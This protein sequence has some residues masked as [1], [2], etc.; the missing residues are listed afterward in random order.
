MDFDITDPSDWPKEFRPLREIDS[1]LRCP[2]CKEYLRAAMMLQ[3]HHNFCSECIRRHLDKESTCPACRVSTSTSQ[4][5]RNV[6]LEEIANNFGDVRQLLLKTVTESLEPKSAQVSAIERSESMDVDD[7]TSQQKRRR[8]SGRVGKA[9]A[10]QRGHTYESDDNDQDDDFTMHSQESAS[11]R[12]Y[13]TRSSM[14]PVL[15]SRGGRSETTPTVGA[16]NTFSRPNSQ[17]LSQEHTSTLD[18]SPPTPVKESTIKHTLVACPVCAAAIPEAYTNT[19]L[20]KFCFQEKQDPVYNIAMSIVETYSP[21]AIA[22]Y[23]KD[24]SSKNSSSVP[25]SPQRS[26]LQSAFS[27]S[28]V[29]FN[30]FTQQ[31]SKLSVQSGSVPIPEPKRLPKLTYSV[32]NDKQLRKKL[33]ELGLPTGGDKQLM[34]K[35]HAEYLTLYNANCDSTRPQTNAQL[36]KALDNWERTYVRDMNAKDTQRRAQEE[37]QQ[38]FAHE[39]AQQKQQDDTASTDPTSL[40]SS[41]SSNSGATSAGFVPNQANNN[42]VSVA[43]ASQ[44]AQ[45]HKLKNAQSYSEMI[46]DIRRRQQQ[47]KEAKAKAAQEA[48][49]ALSSSI[50]PPPQEEL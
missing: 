4:L 28:P 29:R 44:V 34:Q 47:E 41:Q 15:R 10:S 48:N 13:P 6:S 22:A 17:S 5:R 21:H 23:E 3:C 18:Q 26:T 20:D 30:G 38:R 24:G 16:P 33:Q 42:D 27:S 35:R 14:G 50:Q 37:Q 49:D 45:A 31:S 9:P 43:I 25:A 36:L 46:A 12:K 1:H 8:I 19:H 39:L 11:G 2:I 32:L 40:P 7:L